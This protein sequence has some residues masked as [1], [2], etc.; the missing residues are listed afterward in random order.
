VDALIPFQRALIEHVRESGAFV[1][2]HS[3]TGVAE[4]L[5]QRGADA[6]AAR[7][8]STAVRR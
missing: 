1:G 8:S 3:L 5:G 6:D 4:R 2:L 7:R